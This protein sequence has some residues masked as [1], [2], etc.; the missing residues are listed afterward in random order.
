MGMGTAMGTAALAALPHAN[1][2]SGLVRVASTFAV[3]CA[4]RAGMAG[5][6]DP[7]KG[8]LKEGR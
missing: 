4:L 1:T 8:A 7:K 5:I 3:L 6:A 2:L